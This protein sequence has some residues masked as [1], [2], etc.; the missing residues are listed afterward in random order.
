MGVFVTK[1]FSADQ[2]LH[3]QELSQE[4]FMQLLNAA[5]S[6]GVPKLLAC[7]EYYIAVDPS[8]RLALP[9]LLGLKESL[10]KCS[11]F[12]I[13]AA[14]RMALKTPT[15]DYS[16]L[17]SGHDRQRTSVHHLQSVHAFYVMAQSCQQP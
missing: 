14:L 5:E 10:P 12:R 2:N 16:S 15:S 6:Y 1:L 7:C 3:M 8:N 11:A 17:S 4:A 9:A 13:I